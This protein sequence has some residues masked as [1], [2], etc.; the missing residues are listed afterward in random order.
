MACAVRSTA[1]DLFDVQ[2]RQE[3][4]SARSVVVYLGAIL[5]LF[6][7]CGGARFRLRTPH[8]PRLGRDS[9]GRWRPPR[10]RTRNGFYEVGASVEVSEKDESV[11]ARRPQRTERIASRIETG[12]EA[13][14]P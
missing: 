9:V 2:R 10:A 11:I 3:R 8:G 4:L 14:V 13:G 6:S 12:R 7:S 1:P 5:S